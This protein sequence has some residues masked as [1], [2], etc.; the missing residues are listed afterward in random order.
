M[1]VKRAV[2]Y[3]DE[4]E[5]GKERSPPPLIASYFAGASAGAGAA[6]SFFSAFF[7]FLAFFIFFA[8]FI[9]AFSVAAGFSGADCRFLLLREADC[10]ETESD[11]RCYDK[12]KTSSCVSPP[13]YDLKV[14]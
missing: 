3:E 11:N 13:P 14:R 5:R 10:R 6:S 2:V 1:P 9:G 8:F 12:H 7:A 4:R